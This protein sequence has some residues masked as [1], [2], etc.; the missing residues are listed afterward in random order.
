MMGRQ[1]K[2]HASHLVQ[3]SHKEC[4]ALSENGIEIFMLDLK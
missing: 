4:V 3:I 1:G 2:R